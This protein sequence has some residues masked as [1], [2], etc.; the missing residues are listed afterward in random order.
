M[1]PEELLREFALKYDYELHEQFVLEAR[2]EIRVPL[3]TDFNTPLYRKLLAALGV[4]AGT[5]WRHQ[6]EAMDAISSGLSAIV[7]TATGSGKSLIFQF[8][9]IFKLKKGKEATGL[10]I[11]TTRALNN[12]QQLSWRKLME[13]AGYVPE[14]LAVIDGS[15]PVEQRLEMLDKAKVVLATPDIIQA[16]M[17]SNLD[18]PAVQRF[19]AR[20]SIKTYDEGGSYDRYFGA[21]AASL[22]RRIE[23]AQRWF[24][25]NFQAGDHDQTIIASAT[26]RDPERFAKQFTGRDDFWHIGEDRNTAPRYRRV[27]NIFNVG[28]WR[29]GPRN[30]VANFLAFCARK[31]HQGSLMTFI[32]SHSGVDETVR[33]ANRRAGGHGAY[34]AYR[35]G[36]DA[37]ERRRTENDLRQGKITGTVNTSAAET[38]VDFPS[39]THVVSDVL[40]ETNSFVQQAGRA[41]KG[42]NI[43]IFDTADA[44]ESMQGTA[45]ERFE[46]SPKKMVLYQTNA[47]VLAEE[48]VCILEEMR[49]MGA[50]YR[51]LIASGLFSKPQLKYVRDYMTKSYSE[52]TDIQ[53]A[54]IPHRED[55]TLSAH[56]FH[57]LRSKGDGPVRRIKIFNPGLQTSVTLGEVT[58]S[59]FLRTALPGMVLLLQRRLYRV[60][61]DTSFRRNGAIKVR[62]LTREERRE[63]PRTRALVRTRVSTALHDLKVLSYSRGAEDIHA[64]RMKDVRNFMAECRVTV[65]HTA[66]GFVERRLILEED[67]KGV[68]RPSG[69][70][71]L[72]TYLFDDTVKNPELLHRG[73][74]SGKIETETI[75]TNQFGGA[76]VS[77]FETTGVVFR[78]GDQIF[79]RTAEEF[80]KKLAKLGLLMAQALCAEFDISPSDIGFA[81]NA[82]TVDVRPHTTVNDRSIVIYDKMPGSLRFSSN[83]FRQRDK[84]FARML[85]M[86][87]QGDTEQM[88][89]LEA[90]MDW[91][92]WGIKGKGMPLRLALPYDQWALQGLQRPAANDNSKSCVAFL[93]GSQVYWEKDGVKKWVSVEDAIVVQ[94]PGCKSEFFYKIREIERELNPFLQKSGKGAASPAAGSGRK[95]EERCVPWNE[96][97]KPAKATFDLGYFNM[98]TRKYVADRDHQTIGHRK[99]RRA[100]PT[101]RQAGFKTAVAG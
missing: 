77:S 101:P 79:G 78:I 60:R 24:N 55:N 44:L 9:T 47:K 69:R 42:G 96:L 89:I 34:V 76:R 52:L 16:W 92:G 95:L 7:T 88:K 86:I 18:Q 53:Q 38:G 41:R 91:Q 70:K 54:A 51:D 33:E 59:Q 37:G 15:V 81:I 20:L 22:H 75:R 61:E 4:A 74:T 94:V 85:D 2:D 12:D 64:L 1:F 98:T 56:H 8:P 57:G 90:F 67:E 32:E 40:P 30:A 6:A 83:A 5:I 17:M 99:P 97:K 50:S 48:A 87:D 31:G 80:N 29:R 39:V 23:F 93:K 49:Q 45:K 43:T 65:E 66:E 3:P 26:L 28:K 73:T 35:G 63:E 58:Q 62:P 36:H 11:Y 71:R 14:E 10:V 21:R 13:A 25:K 27:F 68:L 84:L 100:V 46:G 72:T 19:F 82:T